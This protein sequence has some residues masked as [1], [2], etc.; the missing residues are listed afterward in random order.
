MP[1]PSVYGWG[2]QAE[3][4]NNYIRRNI[5]AE[6]GNSGEAFRRCLLPRERMY[7]KVR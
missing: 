2:M 4:R 6:D 3:I 1:L 7:A 5:Y